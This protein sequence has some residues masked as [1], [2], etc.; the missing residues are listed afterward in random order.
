MRPSSRTRANA[1]KR[2]AKRLNT[3]AAAAGS[4][5]RNRAITCSKEP[6]EPISA[7]LRD[8]QPE[9]GF[10]NYTACRFP[11]HKPKRKRPAVPL[12]AAGPDADPKSAPSSLDDQVRQILLIRPALLVLLALQ[13]FDLCP[14]LFDVGFLVVE[15]LQVSFV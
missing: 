6:C 15:F 4:P 13:V 3:S 9:K 5:S 10:R 2:W 12:D 14:Q 11:E 7:S 8:Y 1:S